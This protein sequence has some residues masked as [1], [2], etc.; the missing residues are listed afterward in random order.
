MAINIKF[1]ELGIFGIIVGVAGAIVA[2]V[3]TKKNNDISKKIGKS[4]DALDKST[5]VQVQQSI[6]DR[7]TTNAV[8]RQVGGAVKKAIDQVS[9]QIR[10]DMDSMIRKDVDCVYNDLKADVKE[11]VSEEIASL[12]YD[13]MREEIKQMAKDKVFDEF[14]R[15]GNVGKIFVN[16][17]NGNNLDMDQINNVLDQF[18]YSSDKM[19]ALNMLLGNSNG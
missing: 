6:I 14:C 17:R 9:S 7:A 4:I 1:D 8:E 3:V 2:G 16:N 13:K 15:W 18:L 5:V 12:D 10:S 11:R 19:K